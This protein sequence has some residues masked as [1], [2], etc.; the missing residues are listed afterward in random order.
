MSREYESP[1]IGYSESEELTSRSE[2]NRP[3]IAVI[4]GAT[5][6]PTDVTEVRTSKALRSRF[7]SAVNN[8]YAV[9]GAD[10]ILEDKCVVL[11]KRILGKD[12]SQG[13]AG[14]ETDKF[15][16]KVR[17]YD[18]SLEGAI[19]SLTF[20]AETKTVDYT[21]KQGTQIIEVYKKLSYDASHSKYLP[22][23]L[24]SVGSKLIATD[25]TAVTEPADANLTIRGVNNGIESI[26]A[27][28]YIDA[29]GYFGNADENEA[30]LIIIPGVTDTEVQK[31]C[32][33]LVAERGDL[34][35]IPDI[36][37]GTTAQSAL[38]FVNAVDEETGSIQFNHANVAVYGPWVLVNDVVRKVNVWM[39]PSVVATRV[40]VQ[41]D[42]RMGGCW[43]AA[44]GFSD[45]GDGKGG[46][47]IVP[48]AIRCEYQLTKEDRD[49]WQG[50]GNILNPIVYFK[51]LG[52][53]VFGNRTSLRTE[54][55][56]DESFYTSVNIRR[57]ANYIKRLIINVSLKKL[58]DP[59]DPITWASWKVEL[60][61]KLKTI[62][63]GRGIEDYKVVMDETTVSADDI[64]NQQAPGIVYIKPIR[65]LEY[66]P[67]NF[68]ATESS[69]IF[70]DETSADNEEVYVN[71]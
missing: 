16:F 19:I 18:S 54:E 20:N 28:D 23:F 33:K 61:P 60:S 41:S 4:G 71:E 50:S 1:G 64:K 66:I 51:G 21:L 15:T 22:K 3:V 29:L 58:F 30:S 32:M 52:I 42:N 24:E 36:P 56:E 70:E 13:A 69:I 26:V 46:R 67:I 45:G 25:N 35:Y 38:A 27:Q 37:F 12:A 6:G 68:I 55:Y 59:N 7:G 44:A 53:A 11:F 47:G 48:R 65:A 5:K 31:A 62:K 9:L 39:P 40:M 63:D 57:M 8:D 10:Y 43:F 34:M 17:E 49:S 2:V 14:A